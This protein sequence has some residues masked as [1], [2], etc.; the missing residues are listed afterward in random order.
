M[1]KA[2]KFITST[3]HCDTNFLV[4]ILPNHIIDKIKAIPIPTSDIKDRIK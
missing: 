4:N 2:G 1:L 3:K